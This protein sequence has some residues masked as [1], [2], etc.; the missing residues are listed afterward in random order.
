MSYW[1]NYWKSLMVRLPDKSPQPEPAGPE[2]KYPITYM[3]RRLED[4]SHAQLCDALLLVHQIQEKRIE[5]WK[6][7][8]Q[9][10]LGRR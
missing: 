9:I 3:G 2:S 4:L 1:E 6:K 7:L 8:T 10:L 5:D